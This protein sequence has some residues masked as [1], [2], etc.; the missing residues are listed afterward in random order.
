MNYIQF[1]RIIK[2]LPELKELTI[3]SKVENDNELTQFMHEN[4]TLEEITIYIR[5]I[6]LL[7]ALRALIPPEWQFIDVQNILNMNNE[8]N[9][10]YVHT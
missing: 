2:Q 3:T 7:D 8:H 6:D 1:S 10:C 4:T 9:Q 5:H